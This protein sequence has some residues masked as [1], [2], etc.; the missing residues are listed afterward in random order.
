LTR[1]ASESSHFPCDNKYRDIFKNQ[2]STTHIAPSDD[3]FKPY[4]LERR[5]PAVSFQDWY[6]IETAN[7]TTVKTVSGR[8]LFG[9]H[10]VDGMMSIMKGKGSIITTLSNKVVN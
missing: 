4:D 8:G 7:K 2:V 3:P 1:E 10:V 9:S 5:L 6:R